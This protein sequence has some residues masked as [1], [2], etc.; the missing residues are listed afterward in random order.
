MNLTPTDFHKEYD[1]WHQRQFDQAPEHPDEN[2]PW[3]RLVLDYLVP[4]SGKRVLEIAC[5]RG[6]FA[7]LLAAKGAIMFGADFSAA[8]LRIT[9]A[10]ASS[11]ADRGVAVALAQADAQNLPYAS[12][13]FDL[14][15]SCE[16]IEHLPDPLRALREMARVCR[17]G[18]LLYLTTPN[19]L[20]AMGLYHLYAR[21]RHRKSSPGADQPF[22][23]VFLFPQVRRMLRRAGWQILRSDGAVHQF[24]I[25]PRHDPILVPALEANRIVRR[26]LSPLAFHYFVMCRRSPVS[27]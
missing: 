11:R 6:G 23:R 19:Y 7:N 13:S 15:V 20:N 9:Q 2:S 3:Y 25:R 24:P 16:T 22:D 14:L 18:G 21:L 10:K 8:A 27:R 1:S 12:E 26:I 5:G 4:V 17:D